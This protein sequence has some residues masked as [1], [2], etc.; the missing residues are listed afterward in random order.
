MSDSEEP[1]A[2]SREV[3][4]A[5][6]SEVSTVDTY[7]DRESQ[8][9]GSS[10]TSESYFMVRLLLLSKEVG[11][12][13]G[14]GGSTVK[15]LREMTHTRINI[16]ESKQ[17]TFE[18]VVIISGAVE[19][20]IVAIAIILDK[21]QED[22][23][24]HRL[25]RLQTEGD[26]LNYGEAAPPFLKS[27]NTSV[28]MESPSLTNVTSCS[29][30]K[31]RKTNSENRDLGVDLSEHE[32]ENLGESSLNLS[33][34]SFKFESLETLPASLALSEY[35]SRREEPYY[36]GDIISVKVLIPHNQTGSLIGKSGTKIKEIRE[37]S[38][39]FFFASS[40]S[41]SFP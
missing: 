2:S 8:S 26:S 19:N 39:I 34:D 38:G 25:N 10:F 12:I 4:S 23:Y 41:I 6:R 32:S 22:H 17:G 13:I 7:A 27:L 16:S 37:I 21:L 30:S 14:K 20:L 18:R 24:V 1:L 40:I 11:C 33:L 29:P 9:L 35:F 36:N 5:P 3:F 31:K 28:A 15:S